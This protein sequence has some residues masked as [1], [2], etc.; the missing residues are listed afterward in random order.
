MSKTLDILE[1]RYFDW[2]CGLVC[3][4]DTRSYYKKLLCYLHGREFIYTIEMDKNRET[5]G[6]YLR[7]RFAYENCLD[8]SIIDEYL[9]DKPCSV[10]EMM[11]A[12]AFRCEE[13]IMD[14]PDIGNRTGKWFWDMISSLGLDSMDDEKFNKSYVKKIVDR[15]L[16]REYKPNGKGGLFTV[17][18][19][20]CDLRDVE[21][22]YQMCWYLDNILE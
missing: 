5:D 7:Y 14:N 12:L 6:I 15:F 2:I 9:R 1:N 4:D 20:V 18:N 17:D 3:D 10:L 8:S 22:W 19:C 11:V 21:I 13:D 16:N